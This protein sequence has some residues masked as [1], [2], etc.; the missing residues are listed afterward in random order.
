MLTGI[1]SRR[2]LLPVTKALRSPAGGVQPRAILCFESSMG[3]AEHTGSL[4]MQNT[5][6][7]VPSTHW[8]CS[9]SHLH[10][11]PESR[12]GV[13]YWWRGGSS[14]HS[15]VTEVVVQQCGLVERLLWATRAT[16]SLLHVSGD[17]KGWKMLD[18]ATLFLFLHLVTSSI[19]SPLYPALR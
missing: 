9:P 4:R 8:W 19:S 15:W 17:S 18:K 14:G 3:D 6:A 7:F 12:T 16:D 1:F 13:S 10:L 11:S 2:L 5:A